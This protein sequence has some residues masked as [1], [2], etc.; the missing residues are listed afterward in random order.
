MFYDLFTSA[1]PHYYLGS[2]TMIIL[3]GFLTISFVASAF[4]VAACALSARV[5]SNNMMDEIYDFEPDISWD[6]AS[7]TSA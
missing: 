7:H 1:L 5:N 2:Q 6:A 4:V 3:L